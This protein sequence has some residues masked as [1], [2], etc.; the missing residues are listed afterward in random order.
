MS[1]ITLNP[2]GMN[3]ECYRIYEAFSFGSTVIVEQNLNHVQQGQ[4]G[5]TKSKCDQNQTLRLLHQH[6]APVTFI[7][8]WTRDLP[9][10]LD[11]QQ[12][13]S[14]MDRMQ[15]RMQVANWYST[16]KRKMKEKLIQV[17]KEKFE[18]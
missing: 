17:L 7:S 5:Q 13:L 18:I 1:D 14:E 2:L 8:N 11:G 15:R 16:F 9:A 10:I 6:Q 12:N 3:H 4:S